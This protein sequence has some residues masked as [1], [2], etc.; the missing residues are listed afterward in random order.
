MQIKNVGGIVILFLCLLGWIGCSDENEGEGKEL[1]PFQ[2]KKSYYEVMLNGFN[3]SI[4]I[5]NGSLDVSLSVDN[6]DMI[7]ASYSKD[8]ED[9]MGYIR[10]E[11]KQKGTTALTVTDNVTKESS[12]VEIKVTDSYMVCPIE[13]SN[14]PLLTTGVVLFLVNNEA[15]DFYLFVMDHM[16]HKLY[17][18]PS[19]SGTYSFSVEKNTDKDVPYETIPILSLTYVSDENGKP[20]VA[21]IPPT[22]HAFSMVQS[23]EVTFRFLE[24]Y[25]DVDWNQ[26]GEE[27]AVKGD[28]IVPHKLVLKEMGTEFSA[29]GDLDISPRM[30]EHVLE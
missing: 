24:K 21:D 6:P 26:L 15:H 12:K 9:S 10:I 3:N 29:W 23:S 1:L 28:M 5:E 20:I 27:V 13:E 17:D 18:R 11:G 2:M 8:T 16:A 7:D 25:L 4:Y 30:P 22:V 19:Y 14:H